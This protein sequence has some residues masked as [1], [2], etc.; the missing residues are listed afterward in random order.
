MNNRG[1][2]RTD[3]PTDQSGEDP[4]V[5]ASAQANGAVAVPTFRHLADYE[6]FGEIAR[7]GM[8]VVYRARQVSLN[9]PVALKMILAGQFA[10]AEDH[11]RF[12]S[13]AE[14]AA[15][16]D[17][18]NIVPIYEVGQLDGQHFFSMKLVEG[19]SLA[20][21]MSS[22][23][24]SPREGVRLLT[25]VSRA[26]HY[27]HQ[28]GILHRD[29]KPGNILLDTKQEPYVSD[30]GVAKRVDGD[31]NL[32]HSGRIVGTPNYMA[33]EQ[34]SAAKITIT[35]AA[36]VYSLGAILYELL[37]GRA[38]FSG[39][40]PVATLIQVAQRD[41]ERPR[42][43]RPEVDVDLETIALKCLE[44]DPAR[45]Y[46]SAEALAEELERWL[47]GV[48]I[49][50]RRISALQRGAKWAR[51][52]P[53]IAALTAMVVL[54]T[55]LGFTG[56]VWQWRRA[57]DQR[58]QA[59]QAARDATES[60]AREGEQRKATE[61]QKL[62]AD[63]YEQLL[64]LF[65][66][67][68]PK[69]T[70]YQNVAERIGQV[71][72]TISTF[73]SDAFAAGRAL[74]TLGDWTAAEKQY[75]EASHW[76]D[77]LRR[78][79]Q[80]LEVNQSL[81]QSVAD[82]LARV[83]ARIRQAPLANAAGKPPN[84]EA[85][86]R[87]GAPVSGAD[88][89]DAAPAASPAVSVANVSLEELQT[90]SDIAV[91]ASPDV[92]VNNLSLEELRQILLGD[93]HLWSTDLPVTVV[94]RAPLARERDAAVKTVCRMTETE[95]RQHWISKV[96]RAAAPNGPKIVHSPQEAVSQVTQTGGALTLVPASALRLGVKVLTIDGY[97]LGRA[98][99]PLH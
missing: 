91:V 71:A 34:A 22:L 60:R 45:R 61:A 14:A 10:S 86:I 85:P 94:L 63:A 6:V 19:S 96:F 4:T 7:G 89:S 36:D 30:F 49:L 23:V 84:S 31:S 29:I 15:N 68:D 80:D 3:S 37:T 39:D 9:R 8:G 98:G 55:V 42:V 65:V 1:S 81:G 64:G 11:Q 77:V 44:K 46:G 33:P 25:K 87:N 13:E 73:A 20:R 27:A 97:V 92:P 28:R 59:E 32:T 52:R 35:T 79:P 5:V 51:R 48:P 95:F 41:P 82:S 38:P 78:H 69:Q 16:L 26:I 54:L 83:R 88:T 17:H 47:A 72:N 2:P 74:E 53:A 18:P 40:S 67:L 24:Q 50:A 75:L 62:V 93:R 58:A 43:I 57:E 99:Y 70:G 90:T 12:H 56:V 21:Q 76:I 66:Q